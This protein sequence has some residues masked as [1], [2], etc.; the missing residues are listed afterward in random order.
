MPKRQYE[1]L[2]GSHGSRVRIK[3]RGGAVLR[4]P[5]I[6][7]GTAFTHDE[8]EKL[9]LTGLL[10]SHVTPLEAQLHRSYM[11]FKNATTPLSKF[12][13]LQGLRERNSVLFYRLLSE[14]LDEVMPVVYTPTIGEAIQEFS[15]W[16]Q[17]M[18]GVFLS[19]DRP[20]LVEPSLRATEL[21]ADDVDILIVTD[22]EGILGIGDQGVGGIQICN[23]KKS[24][25]TAAAGIDPDRMLSIVLDV[26]TDN[27]KL[28]NDELY[29]GERHARVRGERYDAFVASFVAAAQTVFPNAMIHWEDFGASNAHR[30]LD[31]YRGDICTFND[32]IQG[33]AAVV[34]SAILAGVQAKR[35][36]LGQ[37]RF[38][39]HGGGTAGI[40]IA[41]LLVDLLAKEGL[42]EDEARKLFWVTSS[43][44]LVTDDATQ[45]FRDFQRPYARGIGELADWDLNHPG[46]YKLADIVRNVR[47]T[48]LIGTSGQPDSF[49]EE[50][51]R[52]MAAHVERPL[53][54]PL[55]NPTTL[56]EALPENLLEWTHGRALIATG[57]P[58][59]PVLHDE[60]T[61]TIA[62]A[63]NALVFPGLGLG[64]AVCNAERVTDS[65][66]AASAEA[67]ASLAEAR[68]PGQSLL[69]SINDLRRV[70]ATVAIAVAKAAE[71]DGVARSPLTNPVQQVFESMW[72][73]NYPELIFDE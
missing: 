41:D 17:T 70:S 24:L 55:S 29:L 19:I 34:A 38:V 69:P 7:R 61:H 15:F 26:G 39:I 47:P 28:L 58:F 63:N 71:V 73:P 51:I 42:T 27:L 10:P 48:V 72:M 4:D 1:S 18:D 11:R 25:Y 67:V 65:M 56:A 37:Q 50:I 14:H 44:G 23:G 62:Q 16:F 12:S 32:D 6:N 66:I 45:R 8:R 5:R 49:S 35:E 40:G 21:G 13:Y 68:R 54:L 46:V 22:S 64:V 20:E 2:P 52:D 31:A 60:T 59:Q 9:G 30:L 43:R 33:T 36:K 53:I 3:A 57:S